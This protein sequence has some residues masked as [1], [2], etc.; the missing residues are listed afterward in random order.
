MNLSIILLLRGGLLRP[1]GNFPESLTHSMLVGAMLVGRLGVM[2][3]HGSKTERMA[4]SSGSTIP[5]ADAF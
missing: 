3:S 1:I 2:P 4:L 5:G